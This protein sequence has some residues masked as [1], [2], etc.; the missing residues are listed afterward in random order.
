M[1][2]SFPSSKNSTSTK[3]NKI[4]QTRKGLDETQTPQ[5]GNSVFEITRGGGAVEE[6]Y[7]I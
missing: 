3:K 4:R 7:Q 6:L 1:F 5:D 2:N